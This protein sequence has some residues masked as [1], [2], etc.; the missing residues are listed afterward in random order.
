F[1]R[2]YR[3][4]KT[5]QAEGVGLGLYLAREIVRSQNG[6]VK[7]STHGDGEITFSVFLRR[8]EVEEKSYDK[9]F[10]GGR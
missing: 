9:N 2:F 5:E 8:E 6:Y 1:Q 10:T 4:Q 7:V 3:S